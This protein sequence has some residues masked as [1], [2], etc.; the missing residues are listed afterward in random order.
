MLIQEPLGDY[1]VV[2]REA[3]SA[4]EPLNPA[5]LTPPRWRALAH[6]RFPGLDVPLRLTDDAVVA[7]EP[8]QP[9]AGGDPLDRAILATRTAVFPYYGLDPQDVRD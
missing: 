9:G 1:R 8:W 5:T 3:L 2:L 4:G 6:K 7:F